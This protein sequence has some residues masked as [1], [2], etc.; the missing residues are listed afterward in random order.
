MSFFALFGLGTAFAGT[1]VQVVLAEH[2]GL[3]WIVGGSVLILLISIR[4][5]IH[6]HRLQRLENQKKNQKSDLV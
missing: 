1:K 2:P 3:P 4:R 5:R 6:Y